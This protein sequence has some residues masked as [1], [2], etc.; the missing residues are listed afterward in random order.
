M[1]YNIEQGYGCW[2]ILQINHVISVIHQSLV[3]NQTCSAVNTVTWLEKSSCEQP[4]APKIK[5]RDTSSDTL[6]YILIFSVL[7]TYNILLLLVPQQVTW[8]VTWH[9]RSHVTKKPPEIWKN[10]PANDLM[11]CIHNFSPTES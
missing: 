6:R 3:S 1:S 2:I 8:H 10:F 4:Q 11:E 7:V 9:L 5:P